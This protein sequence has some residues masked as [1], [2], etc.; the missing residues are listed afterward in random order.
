IDITNF[1]H[2]NVIYFNFSKDFPRDVSI[3]MAVMDATYFKGFTPSRYFHST[4]N[5]SISLF[6]IEFYVEAN[7]QVGEFM[8]S[9]TCL[10]IGTIYGS[11][12]NSKLIIKKSKMD[13]QG[14]VFKEIKKINI[15]MLDK[16]NKLGE[17]GWSMVIEDPVNGF[18]LGYVIVRG[19]FDQSIYNISV[20]SDNIKTGNIYLG[21]Y[22]FKFKVSYPC[23]T[24]KYIITEVYLLDKINRVSFFELSS[25]T[26]FSEI[27]PFLYFLNDT[28]INKIQVICSNEINSASSDLDPPIL[29]NF[30]PS[31]KIVDVGSNNR[32]ISF[33]LSSEDPQSGIKIY[34]QNPIIY[35]TSTNNRVLECLAEFWSSTDFEAYYTCSV[36]LP[37]GF[38]YPDGIILS[39]YGFINN[40]GYYSGFTYD[41]LLGAQK[42]AFIETTFGINKAIIKDYYEISE[43]GGDLIL[44]GGGFD[45]S[46]KSIIT[47]FDNTTEQIDCQFITSSAIRAPNVKATDKPYR[48]YVKTLLYESNSIIVTPVIYGFNQRPS[49]TPPPDSV[50]PLPTNKPQ[51]C[52]GSPQCGGPTHGRCIDNQ[53]CVCFK[54]WVGKD[55]LS[56]VV[57]VDPP[58]INETNPSTEIIVPDDKNAVPITYRSLISLV[59]LREID[60]FGKEVYHKTFD[61]WIARQLDNSTFVYNLSLDIKKEKSS[62]VARIKVTLRWF[63]NESNISFADQDLVMSPSSMKYTIEISNYPFDNQIN[64]LQLIFSASIQSNTSKEICSSRE[65]GETTAGDNSEYIK[66]QVENHSLYGRFIRRGIVDSNI[67]SISNILLDKDMNPITETKSL[68]SYVGI[69]IPNFKSIAIIDPDFSVLID[70]KSASSI[71]S[72]SSKLNRSKLAGIIIGTI[73]FILVVVVSI[74]YFFIKRKSTR[75]FELKLKSRMKKLEKL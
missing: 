72:S 69:Q 56:Q 15:Q 47:F 52:I 38:G 6:Q 60:I 45:E 8:F 25:I 59:A 67:I 2:Y 75:E 62:G 12:L 51:I 14:P 9:L 24:Q 7:T 66:V 40:N 39:V 10:N 21:E 20:S 70:S 29:K 3:T 58:K 4:W 65:F 35:L 18:N 26:Q 43:R 30:I 34:A 5:Q 73:A 1:R 61:S 53:G 32:N 41:D 54:P 33:L 31:A 46:S 50:P 36:E 23:I 11:S 49:V 37:F 44:F 68:Q 48:V 27:N 17:F 22:D 28:D 63:I 74:I 19:E 55:C 57:I 13:L 71:C 64:S 42:I 16:N